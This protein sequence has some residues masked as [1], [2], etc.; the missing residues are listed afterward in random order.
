MDPLIYSLAHLFIHSFIHTDRSLPHLSCL[1]SV[2]RACAALPGHR[3]RRRG[4]HHRHLLVLPGVQVQQDH[5]V[6]Q[7]HDPTGA[8]RASTLYSLHQGGPD[9]WFRNQIWFLGPKFLY[10]FCIELFLVPI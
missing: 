10:T 6:V 1:T 2:A 4:D 7:A 8:P 9:L 3:A 5:G